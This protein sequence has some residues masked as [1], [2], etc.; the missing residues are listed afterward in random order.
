MYSVYWLSLACVKSCEV[1]TYIEGML[2]LKNGV[3]AN[4]WEM[5]FKHPRNLTWWRHISVYIN[6]QNC[7]CPFEP[8]QLKKFLPWKK[9]LYLFCFVYEYV[10]FWLLIF[11][12]RLKISHMM[13]LQ[14]GAFLLELGV[15][16]N[17]TVVFKAE[18]TLNL[19]LIVPF[20]MYSPIERK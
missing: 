14:I 2:K 19:G 10:Y 12:C 1:K 16:T 8:T 9:M 15:V 6:S 7:L 4:L 20:L 11:P 17:I 5:C 3:K 18:K 13:R